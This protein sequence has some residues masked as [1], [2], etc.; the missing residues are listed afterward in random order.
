M[1]E[2]I[3]LLSF[4]IVFCNLFFFFF[5]RDMTCKF[6][7]ITHKFHMKMEKN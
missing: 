4:V 3:T 5:F 7:E 2:N 6:M 1:G